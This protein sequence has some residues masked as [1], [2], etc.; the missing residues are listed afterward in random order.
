MGKQGVKK[1]LVLKQQ[2]LCFS[3][4]RL[5]SGFFPKPR[6]KYE[7]NYQEQQQKNFHVVKVLL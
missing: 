1:F 5:R 3:R 4:I 2:A 6:K 7:C